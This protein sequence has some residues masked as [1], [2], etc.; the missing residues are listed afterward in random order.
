MIS[1]AAF[2]V[3][4]FPLLFDGFHFRTQCALVSRLVWVEK[5]V[6]LARVFFSSVS[7]KSCFVLSTLENSLSS[8]RT[9]Y[10]IFCKALNNW[11]PQSEQRRHEI[12]DFPSLPS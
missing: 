6:T 5:C 7:V 10:C 8:V 11:L 3:R 9:C 4:F 2:A 1:L 12:L